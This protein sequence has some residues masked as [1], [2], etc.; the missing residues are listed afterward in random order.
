VNTL[1]W[2]LATAGRRA[3]SAAAALYRRYPARANSYIA[4]GVVAVAGAAGI[5]VAPDSALQI[6]EIVVPILLGGEA[7][8]R[9]VSPAK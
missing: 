4:A 3:A 9:L 8:H 1:L 6:I 2:A 7:T 5:V